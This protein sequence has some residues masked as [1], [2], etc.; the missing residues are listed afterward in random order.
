MKRLLVFLMA[1]ILVASCGAGALAEAEWKKIRV[2]DGEYEGFVEDGKMHGFGML[3]Y[4]SGYT[5][6]GMFQ[7]GAREGF[8]VCVTAEDSTRDYFILAGNFHPSLNGYGEIHYDNGARYSGMWT[9]GS[10]DSDEGFTY[11]ELDFVRNHKR[12]T[13]STYTGEVLAGTKK[14]QGYA[15]LFMEDGAIY[16]GEYAS[17]KAEG[18]AIHVSANKKLT[19]G[20]WKDNNFAEELSWEDW[21]ARNGLVKE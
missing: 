17:D 13:G 2:R 6:Y 5:Y 7:K 10:R 19:I 11:K 15:V 12:S 18:F 1:L 20:V 4:D 16:V 3:T 8:G 9:D 14:G 21:L